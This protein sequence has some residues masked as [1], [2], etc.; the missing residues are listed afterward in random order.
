MSTATRLAER[1]EAPESAKERPN[2]FVH[3]SKEP[4]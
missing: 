1:S 2:P 3:L 4:F